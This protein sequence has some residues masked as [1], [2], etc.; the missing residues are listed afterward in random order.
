MPIDSGQKKYLRDRYRAKA[1]Y[2]RSQYAPRTIDGFAFAGSEIRGWRMH[3]IVRDE[4]AV[5]PVIHSL[6]LRGEA[7]AE[8]LSIDVWESTSV[9]AAHDQLIEVLGNMQSGEIERRTGADE[10]GDVAFGLN[11]TMILFA[12]VN[13]VVL[14][15]NA[16]PKVFPVDPIANGIDAALVRQ[17]G[18]PSPSKRTQRPAAA[19]KKRRS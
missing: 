19:R 13:L 6:W 3:R 1:W 15:R 2:G 10:P 11:D 9:K 4:S 17:L 8:V 18:A 14:T 12:R 16:G 7:A 5:Q